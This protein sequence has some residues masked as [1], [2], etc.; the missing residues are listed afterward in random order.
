LSQVQFKSLLQP[1]QRTEFDIT[2]TLG[3]TLYLV[4]DNSDT[5]DFAT[6]EE[7]VNTF[8]SSIKRKVSKMGGIGRFSW[9]WKRFTCSVTTIFTF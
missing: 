9:K 7:F 6:G 2:K 5:G 4:F 8:L 3:T 1:I